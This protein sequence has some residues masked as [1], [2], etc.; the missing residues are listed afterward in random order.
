MKALGVVLAVVLIAGCGTLNGPRTGTISPPTD[1]LTQWKEFPAGQVPR[2]IVL[3]GDSLTPHGCKLTPTFQPAA[4]GPTT[5]SA[6]WT[7]GTTVAYPAISE[8]E[9]VAASGHAAT[10]SA[11]A[12]S[13][14]AGRPGTFGF[15]TDRGLASMSAWLFTAGGAVG[16]IAYPALPELAFWGKGVHA[17]SIGGSA[18]VSATGRVATF[19][20]PGGPPD[21]VCAE[22][23]TA[24]VAESPAA[25]AVAVQSFPGRSQ[26]GPVSCNE[27]DRVRSVTVQLAKPLDGRVMVDASG[28]VVAV[29]PEA[30]RSSC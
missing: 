7:D 19:S 21:G 22:D 18:T 28:G 14:T 17:A 24:V 5:A 9:A 1:A 15:R 23:Y 27:M 26:G 12:C 6:T 25:V 11:Q 13:V 3:I 10:G 8:A 2:P 16:E 20:F 30:I 4:D 29:C